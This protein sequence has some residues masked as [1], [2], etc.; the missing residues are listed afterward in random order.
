MSSAKISGS[1]CLA[2]EFDKNSHTEGAWRGRSTSLSMTIREMINQTYVAFPLNMFI[3][4]KAH[5]LSATS[6]LSLPGLISLSQALNRVKPWCWSN[7]SNL[8]GQAEA[9]EW[10][11]LTQDKARTKLVASLNCWSLKLSEFWRVSG[12]IASQPWAR[13]DHSDADPF[14]W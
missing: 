9:T 14:C 12:E 6:T 10:H 2:K 4:T 3:E 7:C 5:L 8:R 1:N 13:Y 11:I